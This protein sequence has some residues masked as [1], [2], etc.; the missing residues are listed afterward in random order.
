MAKTTEK[1][2]MNT[3][4]PDEKGFFGNYGGAYLPPSLV[5]VMQ[6]ITDSYMQIKDDP[7]FVEELTY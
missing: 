4:Q 3:Q 7:A 1:K 6:E 5:G 2:S